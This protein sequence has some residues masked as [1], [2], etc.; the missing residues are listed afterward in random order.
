[1]RDGW[2]CGRVWLKIV[3][4]SLFGK[5]VGS[6]GVVTVDVVVYIFFFFGWNVFAF[7]RFVN[8]FVGIG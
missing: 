5:T 8:V 1:M 4:T 7:F 6:W 3:I 2:R